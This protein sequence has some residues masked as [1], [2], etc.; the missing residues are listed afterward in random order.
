MVTLEEIELVDPAEIREI[1]EEA[2]R[3]PPGVHPELSNDIYAALEQFRGKLYVLWVL[4]FSSLSAA[5]LRL[6]SLALELKENGLTPEQAVEAVPAAQVLFDKSRSVTERLLGAADKFEGE[7]RSVIEEMSALAR[8]MLVSSEAILQYCES[9]LAS[10]NR[11]FRR[12]LKKRNLS[13]SHMPKVP[14]TDPRPKPKR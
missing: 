9:V 6:H 14:I 3:V 7:S 8:R 12:S 2:R 10:G 13:V 4:Q 1:E 5:Y 11:A